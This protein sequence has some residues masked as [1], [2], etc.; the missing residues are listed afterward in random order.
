M[1]L[2][3]CIHISVSCLPIEFKM[4]NWILFIALGV[5]VCNLA[6]AQHPGA[7]VILTP[8]ALDYGNALC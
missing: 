2:Y 6:D 7:R 4:L 8:K 5:F 3:I 1:F